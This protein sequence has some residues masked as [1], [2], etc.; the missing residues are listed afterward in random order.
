MQINTD[1]WTS[2]LSAVVT[3]AFGANELGLIPDPQKPIV[4]FIGSAAVVL[5]GALTNKPSSVPARFT[6]LPRK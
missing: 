4:L 5:W 1:K 2:I 6:P 3:C